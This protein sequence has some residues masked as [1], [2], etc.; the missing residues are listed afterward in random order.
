[1]HG[2]SSR[3]PQCFSPPPLVPQ[4]DLAAV[5]RDASLKVTASVSQDETSLAVSYGGPPLCR[6]VFVAQYRITATAR[7]QLCHLLFCSDSI[8]LHLKIT[9]FSVGGAIFPN[10]FEVF[11]SFEDVLR[12]SASCCSPHVSL[13]KLP[14]KEGCKRALCV[15]VCV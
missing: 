8:C 3:C 2:A 15:C 7:K 12:N 4:A 9:S 11:S 1:M 13:F 10:F 14:S 6:S 5:Q